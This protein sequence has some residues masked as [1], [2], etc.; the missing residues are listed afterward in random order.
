MVVAPPPPPPAAIVRAWS[1]A[2][3]ANDNQAAASLFAANARVV[4]P[5]VDVRLTPRLAVLWN[6]A[7]PCGGKI[8]ALKVQGARVT[9]TFLLRERP[10][11]RCDGPGL[12]AAAVF[13]VKKGRIVLWQQVPVPADK[14]PA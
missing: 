14:P 10:L 11:H 8:V 7:L 5:G 2:L 3:N 9:A 4:Q 1:R 12:K 6:D 13:V